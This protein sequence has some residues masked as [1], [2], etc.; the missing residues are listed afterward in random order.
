MSHE[1]DARK[2]RSLA[3]FGGGA[4]AADARAG[5]ANFFPNGRARAV[6]RLSLGAPARIRMSVSDRAETIASWEDRARAYHDLTERW[7]LFGAVAGRLVDQLPEG[8]SGTALD[9]GAGA[10]LLSALVLERFPGA[11]SVLVEPAPAMLAIAEARLGTRVAA[12]HV[13]PA[14]EVGRLGIRADACLAN[15]TAHLFDEERVLAG[16]RRVLPPGAI[17]AFNLWGHSF[18]T[19]ADEPAADWQAVV[20]GVFEE[21]RLPRPE[22]PTA[23][24][25]RV[26]R[27]S[28]LERIARE[29]G[30]ELVTCRSDE[31]EISGTFHL[32]FALMAP[33]WLERVP[34]DRRAELVARAR[35]R[36]DQPI[37]VHSTCIVLVRRSASDDGDSQSVEEG[38]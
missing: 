15:A 13:A 26:R 4:P 17:Y 19:T 37:R 7:P 20:E 24:V 18:E 25:P 1:F 11:R 38:P 3:H 2:A 21:A 32:D 8:F 30:F 34:E 27:R 31:D 6:P 36:L 29:R 22:W 10:G 35:E 33:T 14:E 28:G 5:R 16:L 12:A 9:L 23:A